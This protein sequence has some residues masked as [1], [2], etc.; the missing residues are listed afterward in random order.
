MTRVA[1]VL[2][3]QPLA[4]RGKVRVGAEG[5]RRRRL[6]SQEVARDIHRLEVVELRVRHPTAGP[7]RQR[8][9]EKF[10]EAG[11]GILRRHRPERHRV[12]ERRLRRVARHATDGVIQLPPALDGR[13]RG[14]REGR[15]RA[16]ERGEVM[17]ERVRRGGAFG[18]RQ[19]AEHI[20]HRGAGLGGGGVGDEFAQMG[21]VRPRADRGEVRA[22]LRRQ[23]GARGGVTRRTTEFADQ[24]RAGNSGRDLLGPRQPADDRRRHAGGARGERQRGEDDGKERLHVRPVTG[25]APRFS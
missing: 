11:D 20:G 22:G 12:R 13:G 14:R 1:A 3:E 5:G 2:G 17:R 19:M 21:A 6:V 7:N 10:R 23:V 25:P 18:R 15:R 8:V 16:A 4:A 9:F 24:H